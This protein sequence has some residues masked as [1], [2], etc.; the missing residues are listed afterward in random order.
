MGDFSSRTVSEGGRGGIDHGIGVVN[1]W[2]SID[3]VMAGAP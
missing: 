3:L 1:A 2:D